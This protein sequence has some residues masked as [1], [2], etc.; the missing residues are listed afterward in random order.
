MARLP[1]FDARAGR[2]GPLEVSHDGAADGWAALARTTGE[3]AAGLSRMADEA[4]RREGRAAGLAAGLAAEVPSATQ[5]MP[6]A[7]SGAGGAAGGSLAAR[8]LQEFE[9]FR[10]APYWDVNAWRV[11]FG[12]DTI[13]RAETGEV[14]TVRPGL[15]VTRADAQ[16]DLTRRLEEFERIASASVGENW[17]RLP[18]ASRAA[19]LSV[20]YNYGRLPDSVAAAA[21][22]G[23]MEGLAIAVEGLHHHNGGINATR[24][25]REAAIIRSGVAADAAGAPAVPGLPAPSSGG[26]APPLALTGGGTIRGEAFDEAAAGI[27]V[28]RLDAALS[29]NIAEIADRHRGDPAGMREA[30]ESYVGGVLEDAPD[31]IR[32]RVT[33]R[34]TRQI[35]GHVRQASSDFLK[36]QAEQRVAAFEDAYAARRTDILRLARNAGTDERANQALA[37]ELRDLAAFAHGQEDI[38]P[39]DRARLEREIAQEVAQA[40]LLG[41]F[42][43]LATPADRAAFAERYMAAHDAGEGLA[44]GLTPETHQRVTAAM[45][46]VLKADAAEGRQNQALLGRGIDRAMKMLEQ[47]Q[48][49]PEA[50]RAALAAQVAVS[51]DPDLAAEFAVYDGMADWLERNRAA[52]PDEIGHQVEQMHDL[53]LHHG[54]TPERLRQLEIMEKLHDAASKGVEKDVLGW[55]QRVGLGDVPALDITSADALAASAVRRAAFADQVAQQYGGERWRFFRPGE[56]RALESRMRENAGF[57]SGFAAGLRDGIRPGELRQVLREVSS[58]APVLAHMAGLAATIDDD[59]LMVEASEALAAMALPG[60]EKQALPPAR[61]RAAM[62]EAAGAAFIHQPMV[63]AGAAAMADLLFD[64]RARAAGI[65]AGDDEAD[66]LWREAFNQALGARTVN[67]VEMGGLVQVNGTM[68][69]APADM[70]RRALV[71]MMADL[72][73]EDIA[74]LQEPVSAGDVPLTAALLRRARLVAIG[75]GLYRLAL[76]VPGSED[77]RY[78]MAGPGEFWT[79]DAR[80]LME[81]QT[82]RGLGA[83]APAWEDLSP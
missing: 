77:P 42:D 33:A 9:G 68:T 29:A 79:L 21:R 44:A 12:S 14:L 6:P 17:A 83:W 70:P 25:R 82:A 43:R 80:R 71:D 22:Q 13:T 54:A 1:T 20:T 49:L 34:A 10:E 73:D 60:Y 19:L 58:E 53:I 4:A 62:T 31:E 45:E 65:D 46:R 63:M 52:P 37:D 38:G 40:R 3:F 24:R 69:V 75:D 28:D 81:I 50:E 51:G 8:I 30:L 64:G 2:A 57:M 78:V 48:S 76:G 23:D 67:G 36:D 61:R 11:G 47:G 5:V 56:V 55:A 66:D 27:Y 72:S 16:R 39:R 74:H 35:M 32:A 18:E 41:E 59:T 7:P 15:T 26:P